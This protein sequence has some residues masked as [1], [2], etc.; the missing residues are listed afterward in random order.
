MLIQM[1][2]L[3]IQC[4][5]NDGR[6]VINQEVDVTSFFNNE[7]KPIC[8]IVSRSSN[9]LVIVPT[10]TSITTYDYNSSTSVISQYNIDTSKWYIKIYAWK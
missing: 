3:V 8:S 2:Y 10:F 4:A 5:A 6:F 9:I 1:V 7:T